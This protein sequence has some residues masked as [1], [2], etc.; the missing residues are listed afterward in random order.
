MNWA[1]KPPDETNSKPYLG[2]SGGKRLEVR[3]QMPAMI[4]I[5]EKVTL[6]VAKK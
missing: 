5:K 3:D 2:G 1:G 4:F 6:N